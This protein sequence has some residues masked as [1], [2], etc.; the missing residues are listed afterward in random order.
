MTLS[1]VLRFYLAIDGASL[2]AGAHEHGG[3]SGRVAVGLEQRDA[4]VAEDVGC[5]STGPTQTS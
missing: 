4:P 2:R 5:C 1:S 3:V